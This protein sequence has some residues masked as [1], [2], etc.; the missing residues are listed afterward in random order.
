MFFLIIFLMKVWPCG[1]DQDW[2]VFDSSCYKYFS[3]KLSWS[4]ASSHCKGMNGTQGIF[5][6]AEEYEFVITAV[7]PANRYDIWIGLSDHG[8]GGSRDWKWADG[9]GLTFSRWYSPTGEPNNHHEKCAGVYLGSFH[10][11]QWNNDW[12]DYHCTNRF[13][14]ICERRA[15]FETEP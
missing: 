4:D 11:L 10:G 1:V 15:R 8:Q 5:H 12:H 3:Q 14:F 2:K 7:L 9:S 13:S 6:T